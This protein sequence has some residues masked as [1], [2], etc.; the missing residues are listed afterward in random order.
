MDEELLESVLDNIFTGIVGLVTTTVVII[1]FP[2]WIILY[3]I[4]KLKE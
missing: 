4:K 3:V 2:L 1:T